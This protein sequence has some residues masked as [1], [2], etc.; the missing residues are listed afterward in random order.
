M[1]AAAAN[2]PGAGGG[3]GGGGGG[4]GFGGFGGNR[5]MPVETG[6]YRVTID[7]A[8]QKLV[9]TL[10]VVRVGPDETSVLVPAKR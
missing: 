8:G 4:G 6:D 9:Q 1:L 5:A 10:R 2:A 7:V 3:R